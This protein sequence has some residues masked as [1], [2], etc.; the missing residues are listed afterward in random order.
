MDSSG[1]KLDSKYLE[2]ALRISYQPG[3]NSHIACVPGTILHFYQG[4][5]IETPSPN[6]E[7]TL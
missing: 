3:N 2:G 7:G 1:L 6:E 4:Y 5:L